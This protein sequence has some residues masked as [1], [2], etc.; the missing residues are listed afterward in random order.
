MTEAFEKFKPFVDEE[1]TK[2]IANDYSINYQTSV[3]PENKSNNSNEPLKIPKESE[4]LEIEVS[5]LNREDLNDSSSIIHRML[6]ESDGNHFWTLNVEYANL[7]GSTTAAGRVNRI[8]SS[9]FFLT[10]T[11][12]IKIHGF[13]STLPSEFAIDSKK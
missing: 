8:R 6:Y 4:T 1:T 9:D 7:L 10:Q 5:M 3:N 13:D 12:E 11:Q 2:K